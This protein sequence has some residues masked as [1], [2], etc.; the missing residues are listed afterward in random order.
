MNLIYIYIYI[1]KGVDWPGVSQARDKWR[2][3]VNTAMNHR[4]APNAGNIWTS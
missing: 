2:A 1:Y 4:V 3:V